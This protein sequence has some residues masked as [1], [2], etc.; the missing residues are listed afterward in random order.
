[1]CNG[2]DGRPLHEQVPSFFEVSK[3]LEDFFR[4]KT[5]PH[6]SLIEAEDRMRICL[7]CAK[8]SLRLCTGCDGLKAS[9]RAFVNE[10]TTKFDSHT[11]VCMVHRIP[12]C[13]L[14]H[15]AKVENKPGTPETCWVANAVQ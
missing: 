7:P 15:V 11:G 5:I 12:V 9:S 3:A 1:V 4:G 14:V 2:P 13:A 8:H 6:S 10:R